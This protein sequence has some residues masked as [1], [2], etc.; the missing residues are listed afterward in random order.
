MKVAVGV[1]INSKDQILITQ[2]P[3]HASHGGQWE[4]PGGKLET[5]EDALSALKREIQEEVGL[6][7][8][9]AELILELSHCYGSKVV[10][11]LVFHVKDF[12]GK[13]KCL[14]SQMD[15]RWVNIEEIDEYSF[16]EANIK[17]IEVL[18]SVIGQV[19]MPNMAVS[20]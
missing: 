14:E 19:P 6:A 20:E 10:N 4:F 11:L 5:D 18:K 3:Q 2:R 7:V 13:A 15:L 12:V 17:I 8:H 9:H 1:I 16:P